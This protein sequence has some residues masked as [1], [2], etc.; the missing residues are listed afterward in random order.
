MLRRASASLSS[1]VCARRVLTRAFC[2]GPDFTSSLHWWKNGKDEDAFTGGK[3]GGLTEGEYTNRFKDI[4]P[5][6]RVMDEKGQVADESHTPDVSVCGQ[7]CGPGS[8][9]AW[10][11]RSGTLSSSY[12]HPPLRLCLQLSETQLVAK[13][14]KI[15]RLN[16]TDKIQYDAQRQG[17]ISFYMTSFGEEAIHI[18]SSA[19]LDPE[20]EIFAQY[21]ELG[22]L[23]WR[24]FTVE[25]V[26][27]QC[28]SNELD[29]G[30][31]RQMP[32]HYGS[33]EL[34]FQTI[35]SPLATQIP[36]AAGAAYAMKL[37]GMDKIS[38]CYFGTSGARVLLCALRLF[39]MLGCC[40]S[41][42]PSP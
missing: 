37:A 40:L 1:Q 39:L 28:F 33:K 27:N 16:P 42:S 2:A 18:G 26:C 29:N 36:Q 38:V 19:A 32:V 35:S 17:R 20:D 12:T 30:K 10:S 15:N 6:Y 11:R 9:L 8:P 5:C 41:L 13:Y 7:R 14:E 3:P 21:R 25:Q 31:G 34:H 23:M 4:F 22:V 24:G